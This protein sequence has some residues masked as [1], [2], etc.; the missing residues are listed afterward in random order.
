MHT[1]IWCTKNRSRIRSKQ[2]PV[3]SAV[4]RLE[5]ACSVPEE[6]L[7]NL[8]NFHW[9]LPNKNPTAQSLP[10]RGGYTLSL[11]RPPSRCFPSIHFCLTQRIRS[12]ALRKISS[13]TGNSAKVST[14]FQIKREL[15]GRSMSTCL[16]AWKQSE[17]DSASSF[18]CFLWTL[19]CTEE[20]KNPSASKSTCYS[21]NLPL[22]CRK[23]NSD[24]KGMHS[25]Q[26]KS[27]SALLIALIRKS[28]QALYQ[29]AS[30]CWN[31]KE[32]GYE[33]I[34]SAGEGCFHSKRK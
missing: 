17:Y 5:Y 3:L 28:P 29:S 34:P 19:F 6:T 32:R 9:E 7:I 12:R 11:T 23:N 1:N 27:T 31:Q 21:N 15:R 25:K 20:K 14:A 2:G 22:A 24:T 10:T 16:T 30:L 8:K 13:L 33:I 4:S 26:Q 18:S